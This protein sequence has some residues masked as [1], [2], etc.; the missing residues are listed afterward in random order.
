MLFFK[1]S[2]FCYLGHNHGKDMSSQAIAQLISTSLY[3][4]R[5]FPYYTF[6]VIGGLDEEGMVTSGVHDGEVKSSLQAWAVSTVMMRLARS[7]VPTALCREQA[8]V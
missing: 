5:F 7:S 3:Y 1:P 4:R 8:L 6:N 2:V